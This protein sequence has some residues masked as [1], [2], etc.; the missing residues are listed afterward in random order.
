MEA[1]EASGRRISTN[2]PKL[3]M[4]PEDAAKWMIN[5]LTQKGSLYQNTAVHNLWNLDNS[6]AYR[7]KNG[8]RAIQPSVLDCF[9]KLGGDKVVWS[10]GDR[11]WRLRKSSDAPGLAQP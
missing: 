5:E 10:R 8:N 9:K 6:L 1:G 11:S 2:A 4:T 7:N 3:I